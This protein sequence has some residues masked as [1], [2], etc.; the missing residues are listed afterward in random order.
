[1]STED[2]PEGFDART[3]METNQRLN[4]RVQELEKELA[5][6]RRAVKN[7][8]ISE[9]R[10]YIPMHTINS[11]LKA[12]G[13]KVPERLVFHGERMRHMEMAIAFVEKQAAEWAG[14][15]PA[16]DWG[17]TPADTALADGGRSLL[18]WIKKYLNG[19]QGLP[20]FRRTP[21]TVTLNPRSA[22][23]GDAA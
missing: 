1:M 18:K 4:Y 15:A 2:I 19:E 22:T 16:D 11:I 7:W 23:D 12:C 17:D 21:R 9:D 5:T 8:E 14:R 3:A 6:F 20:D 13:E 10:A